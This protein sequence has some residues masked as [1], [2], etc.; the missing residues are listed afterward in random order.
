VAIP[1]RSAVKNMDAHR[2]V[3]LLGQRLHEHLK[4]HESERPVFLTRKTGRSRGI[5]GYR[6]TTPVTAT[7]LNFVAPPLLGPGGHDKGKDP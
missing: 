1:H 5:R 3:T 7:K 4:L 6:L 2:R